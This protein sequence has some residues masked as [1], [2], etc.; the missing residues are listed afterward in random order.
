M[1]GLLLFLVVIGTLVIYLRS[2]PQR[3]HALESGGLRMKL[4]QACL[5]WKFGDDSP[6]INA[7][8]KAVVVLKYGDYAD[9][10]LR[11]GWHTMEQRRYK[12]KRE[13]SASAPPPK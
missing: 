10:K 7:P 8:E 12:W 5:Y 9:I 11:S 2:R 6:I 3:Y 13:A 1:L 4:G